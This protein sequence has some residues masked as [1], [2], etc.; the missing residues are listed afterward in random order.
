MRI[1]VSKIIPLLYLRKDEFLKE[2]VLHVFVLCQGVLPRGI[3]LP[4]WPIWAH[5]SYSGSYNVSEPRKAFFRQAGVALLCF[6][7][8]HRFTPKPLHFPPCT[9]ESQVCALPHFGLSNYGASQHTFDLALGQRE[10][11]CRNAA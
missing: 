6:R 2:N 7:R 1:H 4:K 8:A 3:V 11:F 10:V 9:P 5:L